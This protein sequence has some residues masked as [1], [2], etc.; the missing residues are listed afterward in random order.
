MN[1][2]LLPVSFQANINTDKGSWRRRHEMISPTEIPL[3]SKFCQLLVQ[4]ILQHS[5]EQTNVLT[6]PNLL[7]EY[8]SNNNI[9]LLFIIEATC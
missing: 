3:S 4:C 2:S 6:C 1:Y 8:P 7:K 5:E 9:N